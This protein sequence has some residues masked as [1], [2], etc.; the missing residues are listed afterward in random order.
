MMWLLWKTVLQKV[1][2]S[3]DPEIP[4]LVMPNILKIF[5]MNVVKI[6]H[7][8]SHKNLH[9]NVRNSVI[10]SSQKSGNNPHVNHL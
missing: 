5:H 8:I 4:F 3:Y 1:K 10:H 9:M 7:K 2:H 6:L